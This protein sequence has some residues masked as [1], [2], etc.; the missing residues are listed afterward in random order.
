MLINDLLN[1]DSP[2]Y[3]TGFNNTDLQIIGKVNTGTPSDVKSMFEL[4]IYS[5]NGILINSFEERTPVFFSQTGSQKFLDIKNFNKYFNES[6][7]NSGKYYFTVNSFNPVIGNLPKNLFIQEISPSRTEIRLGRIV[8]LSATSPNTNDISSDAIA[9][10]GDLGFVGIGTGTGSVN[11]SAPITP[12]TDFQKILTKDNSLKNVYLNF[13]KDRYYRIINIELGDSPA[14]EILIKLY[15]PLPIDIS[16]SEF[17]E[18][19][20]FIFS[21]G[22]IAEYVQNVEIEDPTIEIQG[23]NFNI[24]VD[25]Y[26]GTVTGF[27]TWN[28]LLDVNL[29]TSQQIIDSYFGT[30][31]KGIK[32]NIDYSK[33]EEFVFYSSAEERFNN[34]YYKVQLIESYNQQ[35]EVLNDIN[36]T[37]KDSNIIDV[38]KKRS[39][40]IDGFDDFE[41]YLY[42]GNASSSLYTFYTGSIDVWPKTTNSSLNWLEQYNYWVDNYST[43][44]LNSNAGYNLEN[45]TSTI[46]QEYVVNTLAILKEYDKNNIHSLIK[47]I[48]ANILLNE[49]NSEYLLFVNMIGHHFDIIYTYINHLNKIHSREEHPLD[50][51]SK[52]L[53]TYVAD[54]LGWKLT[55]P[56]KKDSLWRYI[57][58]L[59][60]NSNYIQSSSLT[61]TI[62][63]EQYTLEIWNRIVNNLPF[64]LKTKGTKRSIQALMTCYGIPSTIINIKEYGGPVIKELQ[65]NWQVDKFIYSLEFGNSTSSVSIPWNKLNQSNRVPDSIQFRFKPDPNVVLYPRTLLKTSNAGNPNFYITYDRPSGYNEKEIQLTYYVLDSGGTYKSASLNNVPSL[66]GEWTS[67]L[68]TRSPLTDASSTTTFSISAFVKK[69]ENIIYS[70]TSQLS[71]SNI[72]YVSSSNIQIGSSSFSTSNRAFDGYMNEFRYWSYTLNTASMIEYT[73]N[74][75]FYGGN[76]DSD[77]Y[78]YL[79]FRLPLSYLIT[80]SGSIVSVPSVHTNSTLPSFSGS[81]QATASLIRFQQT[82]LNGE[83]Y[84]TYVTVPS[85]GSENIYSAKVRNVD[86]ILVGSLNPDISAEETN[87]KQTPKDLNLVGVYLSPTETIDSDIY[88]QLGSFSIDDYIGNPEDQNLSYYPLLVESQYQYWKKYKESN[89]FSA[90]YKLLSVYDYSFFDQLKQLLPARVDV[91][92]GIV[93]KQNILERSKIASLNDIVTTMPMYEDTI[94]TRNYIITSGEYPVYTTTISSS[95]LDKP[96]TYNYSSSKYVAGTGVVDFMIRFEPTGSTILRNALSLTKQVFYPIYDTAQSASIGKYN[97]SSSYRSAEVQDYDYSLTAYVNRTYNGTK[98]SAAGYGVPSL[99][100]PDN[101]P[102]ITVSIVSPGNIRNNPVILPSPPKPRESVGTVNPNEGPRNPVNQTPPAPAT[103]APIIVNPVRSGTQESTS[104]SVNIGPTIIGGAS[105]PLPLS[106]P[107][108]GTVETDTTSTNISSILRRF[109]GKR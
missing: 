26:T 59:D 61:P 4:N 51:I 24:D 39:K 101:S 92:A 13:G 25:L 9:F 41:K 76:V 14:F 94:D 50:G 80:I 35:L 29:S 52:D 22:D 89:N 90:L 18:I 96:G 44:S 55:N 69:Y 64:L 5:F 38:T 27:Q 46:V 53:L 33:P 60:S 48:P 40:V 1:T 108:P 7:L 32:L 68:L 95:K 34:F 72:H 23:P 28:D 70:R 57:T 99:D 103:N 43:G 58:G 84:S 15:D 21:Y 37:I 75:L 67:V 77:A 62:S 17:C 12:L 71:A 100:L 30:S 93:I 73:K 81:L 16:E 54:S 31:L 42:F 8:N 6:N 105:S 102:V 49:Y 45:T 36:Q 66:N 85:L 97:N 56:K 109:R 83:D 65:P 87:S 98:I 47:T 2:V 74:P 88:N 20:N 10:G 107:A 78:N 3:S 19:D 82:D 86:P 11:P 63:T 106:N 91:D 79:A 104:P